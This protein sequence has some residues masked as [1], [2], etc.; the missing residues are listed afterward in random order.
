ML[1]SIEMQGDSSLVARLTDMPATVRAILQAKVRALAADLEGY[2]KVNKLDG[3][4][5]NRV[6][7]ALSRSINNR[8]EVIAG[9]VWGLVFSAGD[10]KYAAIHEYGGV[11]HSPGGTAYILKSDGMA[12]FV[13]NANAKADMARTQPHDIHMPERSFMRTGLADKAASISLGMKEAI[14]RGIQKAVTG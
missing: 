7:G 8:V 11:I 14:V 5:L 12:Q 3:Q 2:I 1:V 10:V 4:V 6:T 9:A 13:S